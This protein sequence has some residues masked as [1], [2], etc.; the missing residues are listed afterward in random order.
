MPR[1]AGDAAHCAAALGTGEAWCASPR[2]QSGQLPI[3]PVVACQDGSQV[4]A[5]TGGDLVQLG[6]HVA[7]ESHVH[8]GEGLQVELIDDEKAVSVGKRNCFFTATY[9]RRSMLLMM[10]A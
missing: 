1:L 8:E 4:G 2:F 10:A 9:P 5:L 7:G 6:F 3:E